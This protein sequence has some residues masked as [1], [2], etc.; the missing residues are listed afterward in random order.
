[1]QRI[2][3]ASFAL[4]SQW[5]G[6]SCFAAVTCSGT[7]TLTYH[8]WELL[9][10]HKSHPPLQRTAQR[11]IKCNTS[12]PFLILIDTSLHNGPANS[13]PLTTLPR[14]LPQRAS[15]ECK[16]IEPR[17]ADRCLADSR[18]SRPQKQFRRES[19]QTESVLFDLGKFES[20]KFFLSPSWHFFRRSFR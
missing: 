14:Q 4:D 11:R 6:S 12:S 10:K 9:F 17:S 1:M 7:W 18:H 8:H 5:C 3:R 20:C 2:A 15:H 19:Q 13:T 16:L